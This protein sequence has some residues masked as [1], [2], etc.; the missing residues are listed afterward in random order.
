M[1]GVSDDDVINQ[2]NIEER[3]GFGK[4]SR[5][6]GVRLGWRGVAARMVVLCAV[7]DYVQWLGGI[8]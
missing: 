5:H 6:A 2:G 7:P 4:A 1:L 3:S 8:F